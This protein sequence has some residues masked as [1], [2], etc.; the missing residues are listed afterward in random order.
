MKMLVASLLVCSTACYSSK[1]FPAAHPA[2][3]AVESEMR[4][5]ATANGWAPLKVMVETDWSV[6]RND[7]SGVVTARVIWGAIGMRDQ[8]GCFWDDT[9]FDEDYVGGQFGKMRVGT[10]H[11]TYKVECGELSAP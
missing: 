4:A 3:P 1:H 7:L 9:R 2:V 6:Y 8:D 10:V 11:N 5:A